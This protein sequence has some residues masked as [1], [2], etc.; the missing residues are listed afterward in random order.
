MQR[1]LKRAAYDHDTIPPPTLRGLSFLRFLHFWFLGFFLFCCVYEPRARLHLAADTNVVDEFDTQLLAQRHFWHWVAVWLT[2]ATVGKDVRVDRR[3]LAA[4]AAVWVAGRVGGDDDFVDVV[5]GEDYF[6]AFLLGHKGESFF[7]H[8]PLVVVEDDDQFV[9][10]RL[11][12]LEHTHVADMERVEAA[13]HCHD[14]RFLL[15][16][17]TSVPRHLKK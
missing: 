13:R 12:V 14:D 10:E 2:V 9:A 5:N 8:E 11:C 17:D 4:H 1:G 15:L 16:H 7:V 3:K 6:P